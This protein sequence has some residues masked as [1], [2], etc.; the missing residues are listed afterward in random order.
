MI[1]IT[2]GEARGRSIRVYKGGKVRPTT[3]KVRQ[4]MFNI[5]EHRFDLDFTQSRALDLYAGSGSLGAEYLSRGGVR[6][7]S[8]ESERRTIGTL[9]DNLSLIK[10]SVS[11]REVDYQVISQRVERYLKQPPSET[12]HII[13]A[14]PPYSERLA[15]KLLELLERGW[16][17]E[18]SVVIIE[19][20]KR[21]LFTP[22]PQWVLADRRPYGETLLSFIT[23]SP[24]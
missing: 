15:L 14:D 4:A 20:E 1:R 5:L 3:D 21:D 23:R 17:N 12:F 18:E 19:H 22:G 11:P 9:K 24:A 7:T 6:L 13:F 2:G 8:V 10:E 16:V